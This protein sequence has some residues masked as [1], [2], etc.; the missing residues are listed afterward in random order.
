M[1]ELRVP[2]PNWDFR[3]A[4]TDHSAY[5]LK[6]VS[7]H[8]AANPAVRQKLFQELKTV[9]PRRGDRPRLHDVEKLPYLTAIIQESLRISQPVTHR[10]CRAFPD[11]ALTYNG[12]TIPPGTAIHSTTLLIH[13]NG[14]LFPDP[15]AFKPE[16]WLGEEG[17]ELQRYLVPF[18]RGTRAC[19]GINLAWAELYLTVATI[20]RRFD[21]DVSGV[22]RQRDVDVAADMI[23]P[24]SAPD[25]PGTIV[26]ALA[27]ED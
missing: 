7:Y 2:Q 10:M 4:L 22:V 15:Q 18:A 3:T 5:V 14:Q 24:V 20:F 16:R 13:E 19:L 6:A 9:I 12:I 1:S 27:I 23:L 25:S 17:Q 8:I 11:K 26:K 21:F